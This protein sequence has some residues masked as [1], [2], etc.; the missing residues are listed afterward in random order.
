[1][2]LGREFD[3]PW[4]ETFKETTQLPVG[5]SEEQMWYL[6]TAALGILVTNFQDIH[7]EYSSNG[8]RS[9][10]DK[11]ANDVYLTLNRQGRLDRSEVVT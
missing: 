6:Q 8:Q 7:Q 3:L 5:V 10:L 4:F 2:S 1:M 9:F 11:L